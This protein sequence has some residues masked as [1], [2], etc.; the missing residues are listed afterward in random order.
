MIYRMEDG[1]VVNTDKARMIWEEATDWNGNNHISR[2]T[3]DQWTHQTLYESRKGR[4]YIEHTSQW[5]GSL[6]YCEWISEQAA[7]RWLIL[8]DE[9]VP[10]RLAHLVDEVTE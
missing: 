1:T 10:E 8:N 6:G 5:Q 9:D 2:N 3:R 4:F 7:V